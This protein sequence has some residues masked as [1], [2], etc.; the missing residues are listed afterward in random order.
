MSTLLFTNL[1]I[2]SARPS[3]QVSYLPDSL[4]PWITLGR[5]SPCEHL[6][7]EYQPEEPE[8]NA[9]ESLTCVDCGE[10]LQLDEPDYEVIGDII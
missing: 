3:Y 4:S 1:E 10:D 5:V 2:N 8:S 7:Q 9:H 6:E